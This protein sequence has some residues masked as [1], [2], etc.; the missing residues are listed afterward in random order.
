GT[1]CGESCYVLPCFTV[2]CTC[3]SSQCFK[4]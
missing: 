3:T 4:N 2:G 1:A